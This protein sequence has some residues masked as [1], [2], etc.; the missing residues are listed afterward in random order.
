MDE[1][2]SLITRLRREKYPDADVIFLAGSVIRGEGTRT[3][4]L[5]VVVAYNSLPNAWRDSYR[6]G[7]WPVEAF[8][9]DP[10]TLDYFIHKVDAPGGV[11]SLAA[12]V[13]EGIELPSPTELSKSLKQL[14]NDALQ[15]GPPRWA[16]KDIDSSRYFISDLIEDLKEPRTPGEM[17]A[18][19][20]QLYNAIANHYFR[21]RGLWSANGKTIPRRLRK[22]DETFA[23]RFEGAFNSVFAHGKP[24]ELIA[25]AAETLSAHGG[26][27]FEGHRLEAPQ[28]WRIG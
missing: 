17:Y 28:D 20:S 10:Q 9:H 11:P 5:D 22:I 14:A 23:G 16:A 27:L 1:L 3:S 18:I 13:S 25:L 26:F 19:A 24:D 8:V 12:M 4:D 7:G 6:Y 21:S 15:A 2:K